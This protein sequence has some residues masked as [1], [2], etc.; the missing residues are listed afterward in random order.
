MKRDSMH[1]PSEELFAYRDGQLSPERRAIIEAHVMGCSVCRTFIDQV[2][3][4][5]AELRQSPDRVPA[6]YFENLQDK[7]R[8]RIAV[9]ASEAVAGT[10]G[11]PTGDVVDRRRMPARAGDPRERRRGD[12]D[13]RRERGRVKEAPVLPWAAVISTVSAAAA[14][15]VV[16]AILIKQGP[17]QRMITPRAPKEA[18][19]STGGE[20]KQ[21]GNGIVETRERGKKAAA[22]VPGRDEGVAAPEKT[23]RLARKPQPPAA[24]LE[25]SAK[26]RLDKD[27]N[28]AK[29]ESEVP[30]EQK[31][32][33]EQSS[34]LRDR[35]QQE[36]QAS[37]APRALMNE[38][39]TLAP[40]YAAL[41]TRY[42]LP[43]IWDGAR[44]SPEA[45]AN[46]EPDLR[47]LYV[48]GG[49]GSDSARVRLYLAEAVRL[50]YAPGDSALYDEIQ[51]H[52]RRAID[53]AGP[54]A[55]TA[56]VAEE[57]LRSLER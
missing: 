9:A 49:A 25:E 17:Y 44:V 55:E 47:L 30:S 27:E 37:A 13:L 41:L 29:L 1:P 56:R 43:P 19:P 32:A 8:A 28:Q 38:S 48:S 46:A 15:L 57:R 3:S 50:R 33:R 7:V 18:S 35:L 51:H 20:A 12:S 5:E 2:S 42:H 23:D 36:P 34:G 16:V 14:V 52:Y 54:D 45:L 39:Q 10:K 26:G 21:K 22:S 4:L 31:V 53:L 24:G 11:A 6:G 40:A